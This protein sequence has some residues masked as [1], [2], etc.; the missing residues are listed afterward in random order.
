MGQ[1]GCG[2]CRVRHGVMGVPPI[3]D[4]CGMTA[5]VYRACSAGFA[6]GY[7]SLE[8]SRR[9]SRENVINYATRI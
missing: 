6:E 1:S 8:K 5:V 7:L 2:M 3:S 9:W 4:G